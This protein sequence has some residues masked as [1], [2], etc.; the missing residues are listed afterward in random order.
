[1]ADERIDIVHVD[2]SQQDFHDRSQWCTP[3]SSQEARGTAGPRVSEGAL[4][5]LESCP[6]VV[7]VASGVGSAMID[8]MIDRTM[9]GVDE[10]AVE[11]WRA[12][13]ETTVVVVAGASS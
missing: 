1:M 9:A 12:G 8:T 11:Q 6:A 2:I 7:E 13:L 3:S 5:G 4:Q 10:I